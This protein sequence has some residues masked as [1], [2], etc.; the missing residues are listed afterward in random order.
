MRNAY[1][2]EVPLR[3]GV[4]AGKK[5]CGSR[6]AAGADH[7]RDGKFGRVS[8][9]RKKAAPCPVGDASA[10]SDQT[11]DGAGLSGGRTMK[12]LFLY[13]SSPDPRDQPSPSEMQ[14]G[15]ARWK[16]WMTKYAKE[17]LEQPPPRSGPMPGGASA[18]STTTCSGCSSFAPIPR[19]RPSRSSS[20]R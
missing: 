19:S 20:S 7:I 9:P 14:A 13:R 11:G 5:L 2:L 15:Y 3:V 16:S 18:R 1:A 17:I 6:A 8:P 10:S 4:E 12:F